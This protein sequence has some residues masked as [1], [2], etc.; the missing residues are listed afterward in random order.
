MRI[1]EGR[2][3]TINKINISGN[4]L[5]YENVVRREL[6]IPLFAGIK[7]CVKAYSTPPRSI[8]T[9]AAVK[10]VVCDRSIPPTDVYKRQR[11]HILSSV[12]Q[13]EAFCRVPY[14]VPVFPVRIYFNHLPVVPLLDF[15]NN[16]RRGKIACAC[17]LYTSYA[18]VNANSPALVHASN[19]VA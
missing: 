1:Y 9:E 8:I 17:L 3:A 13:D 7:N 16:D 10:S 19:A 11:W 14:P 12:L 5:L 6:R 4:D 2:Q 15:G 18:N